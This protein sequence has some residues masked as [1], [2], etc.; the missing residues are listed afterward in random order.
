MC[1]ADVYEK[2][3]ERTA[4]FKTTLGYG[5]GCESCHGPGAAHV[6]GGSDVSKIVSFKTLS[7]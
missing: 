5:H 4:H 1:H 6:A 7:Q 2:N 3:F